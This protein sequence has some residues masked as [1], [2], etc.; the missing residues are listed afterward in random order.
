MNAYLFMGTKLVRSWLLGQMFTQHLFSVGAIVHKPIFVRGQ[1]DSWPTLVLFPAFIQLGSR[2]SGHDLGENCG[3]HAPFEAEIKCYKEKT[4]FLPFVPLGYCLDLYC[5]PQSQYVKGLISTCCYWE[6]ME[7]LRG[8]ADRDTKLWEVFP[9]R[10]LRYS[11]L[12]ITFKY[13]ATVYAVTVK[14]CL[15]P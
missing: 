1:Q 10:G 2:F 12:F 8:E 13:V 7:P 3:Q 6:V 4:S 15:R 11:G 9:Q 14:C 5:P